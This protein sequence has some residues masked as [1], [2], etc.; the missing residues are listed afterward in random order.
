MCFDLCGIL[1]AETDVVASFAAIASKVF[2]AVYSIGAVR[3]S[4]L[5]SFARRASK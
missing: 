4:A 3:S 1:L 2:A 5:D